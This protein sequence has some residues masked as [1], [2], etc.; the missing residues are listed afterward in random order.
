MRNIYSVSQVNAYI[1]NMFTQDFLLRSLCVRGEISNCKYHSSGHIY[2]TLKDGT[3]ALSCVMFRAQRE[4]GLA[5][6]LTDGDSVRVT[7]TVDVYERDGRYQ[8]YAREIERDGLG[9]LHVRF[10][11]LKKELQER[12]MFD[13]A[14]KRPI[15]RYI[16]TLG[17]VTAKTGAAVRDIISVTQ[18]RNPH[19]RILLYPAIVQGD[20]APGSIV[21]GIETLSCTDADVLI[22]GRGGGSIEDLWA[23]NEEIVAQAIFDCPIPVISAVGHETDTTIADFVADKRAATPS[24]AAELAVF[25]YG[26]FLQ[27]L[28]ELSGALSS[29][30][31]E[32]MESL[33]T[34]LSARE[35]ELS[36]LSPFGRI[37]SYRERHSRDTDRLA[38]AMERIITD[39]RHRLEVNIEK[40]E[41]QSPLRRLSSGYAHV[42]TPEGGTL[43]SVAQAEEGQLLTIYLRD[44]RVYARTEGKDTDGGYAQYRD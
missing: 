4:K 42:E 22:V 15:P 17:V 26:R 8:L 21:R 39:R 10:E 40:L 43:R 25:E 28:D 37:R 24:V 11:Q 3:G 41:G 31:E 13:Q 16:R 18:R 38:A 23:F 33:R 2:F 20:E 7:G 29:L 27:E 5:F 1:R 36:L 14:Y 12:G 32:R 6:T 35:R 9:D 19:V 34:E 44:G 30:M